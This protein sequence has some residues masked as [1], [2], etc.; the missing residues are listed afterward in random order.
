MKF[1]TTTKQSGFLR[2]K[3]ASD[4]SGVFEGYGAIYGN[5]DSYGDMIMPGAFAKSLAAHKAAGTLPVMLWGHDSS[6]PI[7]R[8]LE[9]REDSFGLFV[10]GQCNLETTAGKDAQAHIANGDV[11]GMSI[12]YRL[13]DGGWH[14]DEGVTKLTEIDLKEVSVVAIPANDR[15][16]VTS[17]ADLVDLLIKTGLPRAA[18]SK[19]AAGGFSALSQNLHTDDELVKAALVAVNASLKNL[20]RNTR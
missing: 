1:D 8:W 17:K 10:R 13:P 7:G 12:G 11:T 4:Q 9:V 20:E 5:V 16:R 15:A 19:V 2:L 6:R 3:F 14:R 18:A